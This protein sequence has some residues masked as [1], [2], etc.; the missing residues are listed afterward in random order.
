[1]AD[2]SALAKWTYLLPNWTMESLL[3]KR[4]ELLE[5]KK[6]ETSEDKSNL[7]GALEIPGIVPTPD[8]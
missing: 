4:S 2:E 3:K 5:S 1:M 8:Q 6:E 7:P